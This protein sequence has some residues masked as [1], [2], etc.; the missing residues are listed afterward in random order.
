[1]LK[2]IPEMLFDCFLKRCFIV[3]SDNKAYVLKK[4][5]L[6]SFCTTTSRKC[7]FGTPYGFLVCASTDQC[8]LAEA[9]V[10]FTDLF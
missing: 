3:D 9:S 6:D 10:L 1:M 7:L 8:A 4:C 2:F 5:L